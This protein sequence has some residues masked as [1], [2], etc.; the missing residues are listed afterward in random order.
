MLIENYRVR[1]IAAS[2]GKGLK[3]LR[4]LTIGKYVQKIG[5]KAFCNCDSLKTITVRTELL[6]GADAIGANAFGKGAAKPTVRCPKK[7]LKKY[8]KWLK[9]KGLPKGTVFET[10]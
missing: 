1:E 4:S 2:A 8:T 7:M 10:I 5:K 9:Q 6:A 3:K